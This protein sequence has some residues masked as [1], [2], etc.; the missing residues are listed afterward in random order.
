AEIVKAAHGDSV[1]MGSTVT[2]EKQ[3]ADGKQKFKIVGSDEVSTADGKISNHSP[4]G[5]VLIGKRKGDSVS[6]KTP[7]GVTS[8]KIVSVE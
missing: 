4:L 1:S 5:S 6:V 3:G 8:Y 2:V 7:K